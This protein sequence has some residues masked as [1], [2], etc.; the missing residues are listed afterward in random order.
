LT[1]TGARPAVLK[2]CQWINS[3]D[4]YPG[5]AALGA[6]GWCWQFYKFRY[7]SIYKLGIY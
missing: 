3:V 7:V 4:S 1:G 2:Y 5:N 6:G